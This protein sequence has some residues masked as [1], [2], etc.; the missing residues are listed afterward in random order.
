MVNANDKRS[1]RVRAVM[2]LLDALPYDGKDA[3][4]PAPPDPAIVPPPDQA[5]RSRPGVN[6]AGHR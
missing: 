6:A 4:D 5:E 1:V 2:H 3:E